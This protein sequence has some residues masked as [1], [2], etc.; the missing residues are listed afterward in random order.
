M[1]GEAAVNI[2]LIL[3]ASF[4][5]VAAPIAVLLLRT[6]IGPRFLRLSAYS[7]VCVGLF[8]LAG[9]LI[10]AEW[11]KWN[12]ILERRSEMR[13][14]Y[15]ESIERSSVFIVG[16]SIGGSMERWDWRHS[17]APGIMAGVLWVP[18]TVLTA[19]LFSRPNPTRSE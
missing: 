19:W 11:S 10:F 14:S 6:W 2:I 12:Y 3:L 16:H 17:V 9:S 18:L 5:F 8:A 1:A 7:V 15:S 4:A 13:G